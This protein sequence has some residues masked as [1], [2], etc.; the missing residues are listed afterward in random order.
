MELDRRA[1]GGTL[2]ETTIYFYSSNEPFNEFSNFSRH[3]VE[4]DGQWWPTVEHYFQAQKFED[5]EYQQK[6][7]IAHSPKEAAD[8]GRSRSMPLR[9]EWE[10]VKDE[11]MAKAVLKKFQDTSRIGRVVVIYG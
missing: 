1:E 8:L 10:Q 4:L 5:G 3:G 7:R 6:I 9:A 2:A 11:V